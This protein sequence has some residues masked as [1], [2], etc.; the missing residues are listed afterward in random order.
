MKPNKPAGLRY[1]EVNGVIGKQS[2]LN[3]L[4]RLACDQGA[5]G[6]AI[7]PTAAIVVEDRL[8]DLCRNPGCENYGLSASCPP[9]VSGPAGFRAF[10]RRN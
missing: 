5:C 4:A 7:I 6:A 9:H 8:A 3:R 2:L 10:H 1:G